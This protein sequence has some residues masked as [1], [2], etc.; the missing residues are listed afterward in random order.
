MT[1][2]DILALTMSAERRWLDSWTAGPTHEGTPARRG[3]QA[4]DVDL[5]AEDGST[6]RLSEQ[7]SSDPALIMLWRHL[8]CG[9]GVERVGRLID[10]FDEYASSGL[11]TVVVA[12]GEIE[13]VVAYKTRHELPSRVLADP[14]YRTHKAF[15]LSHWSREQVLY[16]APEE[17]CT[18]AEDVGKEFQAARR[19]QGTPLVDDPWMQSGEFVVGIDGVIRVSYLYNYCEDYPD[20]RV[21]TT[22]ARLARL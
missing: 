11:N 6:V 18:L 4:P 12:P 9:C 16:D 22:A 15:G 14:D 8:G 10:E 5:I 13:R 3:E 7:W 20:P 19:E 2:R 21:F 17:F 1:D